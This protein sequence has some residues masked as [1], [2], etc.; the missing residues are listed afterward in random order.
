MSGPLGGAMMGEKYIVID[1]AIDDLFIGVIFVSETPSFITVKEERGAQIRRSKDS[2]IT[3][4]THETMDDARKAA[5]QLTAK[6]KGARRHYNQ[7]VTEIIADA[8]F[9]GGKWWVTA[10][11][12]SE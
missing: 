5:A 3:V 10:Q 9:A 1:T 7:R 8:R 6:L 11:K 4:S 12:E 2:V